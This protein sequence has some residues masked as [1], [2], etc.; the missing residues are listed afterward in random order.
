[1]KFP[2]T[3]HLLGEGGRGGGPGGCDK[4]SCEEID[5]QV[6]LVHEVQAGP[7]GHIEG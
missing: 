3:D 7:E 6:E 1:M 4:C 2:A 5:L